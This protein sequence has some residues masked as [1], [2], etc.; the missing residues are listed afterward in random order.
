MVDGTLYDARRERG[1]VFRRRVAKCHSGLSA[2]A[3][4][5]EVRGLTKDAVAELA[6][7]SHDNRLAMT[8]QVE[9]G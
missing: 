5:G 6:A 4:G 3:F 8:A 1:Y 7:W 9:F 2:A